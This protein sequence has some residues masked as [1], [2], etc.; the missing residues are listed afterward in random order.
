M[1]WQRVSSYAERSS[2]SSAAVTAAMH[3]LIAGWCG[4]WQ[5]SSWTHGTA[6]CVPGRNMPT[7]TPQPSA[8]AARTAILE[9]V[10]DPGV[11][12]WTECRR[13]PRSVK[14]ASASARMG[15]SA[16]VHTAEQRGGATKRC[17]ARRGDQARRVSCTTSMAG[18]ASASAVLAAVKG[19]KE[20]AKVLTK[21]AKR[22][23]IDGC[24]YTTLQLS[25]V[26]WLRVGSIR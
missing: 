18:R 25:S 16:R 23:P 22:K 13:T 21:R 26:S 2:R 6:S 12:A 1:P 20:R 19:A 8:P 3:W 15:G 24:E 4:R 5:L 9:C 10:R 14:N 17:E 7:V 11:P